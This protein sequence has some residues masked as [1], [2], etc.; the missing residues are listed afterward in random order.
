MKGRQ[1]ENIENR[2]KL[3]NVIDKEKKWVL[4]FG[5]RKR[6]PETWGIWINL[7]R[8]GMMKPTNVIQT[9]NI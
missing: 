8:P 3:S 9:V 4:F 1:K 5:M 6:G 7:I 2:I